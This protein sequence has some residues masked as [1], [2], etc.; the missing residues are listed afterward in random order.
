MSRP[1]DPLS[2]TEVAESEKQ[3]TPVKARRPMSLPLL[4]HD[5][6]IYRDVRQLSQPMQEM[7][8]ER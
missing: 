3:A 6:G 2:A 1:D 5:L 8:H 4:G 7:S